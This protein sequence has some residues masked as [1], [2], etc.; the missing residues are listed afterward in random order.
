MNSDTILLISSVSFIFI[1]I[2]TLLFCCCNCYKNKNNNKNNNKPKNNE[3][4]YL[5]V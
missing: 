1:A 2:P 5:I 3:T 4:Q